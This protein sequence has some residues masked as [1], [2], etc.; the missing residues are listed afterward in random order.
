MTM[1]TFMKTSSL[2]LMLCGALQLTSA[3]PLAGEMANSRC[4][5]NEINVRIP[6]K[7]LESYYWTSSSCPLKHIV[8]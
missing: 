3:N 7:R 1:K 6:L 2:F 8:S 5:I 4:C